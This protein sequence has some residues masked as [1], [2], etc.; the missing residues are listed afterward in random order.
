MITSLRLLRMGLNDYYV[1][2]YNNNVNV[3]MIAPR[4]R[5]LGDNLKVT[6]L[7]YY[8]GITELRRMGHV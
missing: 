3:K 7:N 1:A 5:W 4:S 6:R 2:T 8:N